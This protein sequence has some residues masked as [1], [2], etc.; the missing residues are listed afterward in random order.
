MSWKKY[1]IMKRE[2]RNFGSNAW[3]F[4]NHIMISKVLCSSKNGFVRNEWVQK[5]NYTQLNMDYLNNKPEQKPHFENLIHIVIYLPN[6]TV[7]GKSK[8]EY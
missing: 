6:K 2:L 7:F 5:Q 3:F 4:I 1:S 8:V